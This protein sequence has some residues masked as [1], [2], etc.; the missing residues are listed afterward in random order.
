MRMRC[1]RAHTHTHA[2]RHRVCACARTRARAPAQTH[3]RTHAQTW[4]VVPVVEVT[5]G[6]PSLR[7]P[8]AE[9][10]R[11]QAVLEGACT[12]NERG[13]RPVAEGPRGQGQGPAPVQGRHGTQTWC[14]WGIRHSASQRTGPCP[15]PRQTSYSHWLSPSWRVI[16][17]EGGRGRRVCA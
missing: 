1:A 3:T 7:G 17:E 13:A 15:C 12:G 6:G 9:G 16:E 5:V 14:T 4:V 11:G 10:P 2:R 8:V